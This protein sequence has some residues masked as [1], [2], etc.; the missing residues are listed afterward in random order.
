MS[1][2]LECSVIFFL[3]LSH[4]YI[5]VSSV[6]QVIL[7]KSLGCQAGDNGIGNHPES[8]SPESWASDLTQVSHPPRTQNAEEPNCLFILESVEPSQL[9]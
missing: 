3:S 6:R 5:V 2:G 9:S 7:C 1:G 8:P 4:C